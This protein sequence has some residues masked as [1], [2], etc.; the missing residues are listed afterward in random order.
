[1]LTIASLWKELRLVGPFYRPPSLGTGACHPEFQAPEG[2]CPHNPSTCPH[3]LCNVMPT[4][5]SCQCRHRA[6]AFYAHCSQDSRLN[7]HATHSQIRHRAVQVWSRW[8]ARA[9]K[10][11][12]AL[13]TAAQVCM[14]RSTKGTHGMQTLLQRTAALYC[15]RHR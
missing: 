12:T 3:P 15:H 4:S 8:T 14:H 2:C 9:V 13:V 6:T 10:N 7:I 1:M 5:E 11:K